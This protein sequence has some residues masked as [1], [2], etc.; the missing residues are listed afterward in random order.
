M[1]FRELVVGEVAPEDEQLV[2]AS[3]DEGEQGTVLFCRSSFS[4]VSN[5]LSLFVKSRYS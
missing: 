5:L 3:V 1:L 2:L 4:L